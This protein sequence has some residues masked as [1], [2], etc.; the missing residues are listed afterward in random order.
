[1]G[2]KPFCPAAYSLLGPEGASSFGC[3]ELTSNT[4]GGMRCG[5]GDSILIGGG[6]GVCKKPVLQAIQS[7]DEAQTLQFKDDLA[8]FGDNRRRWLSELAGSIHSSRELF[9]A[10]AIPLAVQA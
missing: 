7:L 2:G 10:D 4:P 8:V 1:M 9:P 3:P 5:V 6:I